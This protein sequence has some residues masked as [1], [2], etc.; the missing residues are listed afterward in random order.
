M[1]MNFKDVVSK[2]KSLNISKSKVSLTL[3]GL[4]IDPNL[5]CSFD[6]SGKAKEDVAVPKSLSCNFIPT[7]FAESEKTAIVG[8]SF[9]YTYEFVMTESLTVLPLNNV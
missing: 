9:D 8:V 7:A 2:A 1:E 3:E 4:Q 6:S 5:F